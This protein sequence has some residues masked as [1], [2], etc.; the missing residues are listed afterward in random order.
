MANI[1]E[2]KDRH[3][4]PNWRSFENT[5]KLGELNGSKTIQL[6]SSFKPDISDLLEDW[7]ENKNLGV[8]GD[9]LGVAI[10]CNQQN[11]KIV[12]DVSDF[13]IKQ[14]NDATPALIKAANSIRQ[15]KKEEIDF[16]FEIKNIQ[17]FAFRENL[18]ALFQRIKWYKQRLIQNPNNPIAWVE[19]SRLYSINGQ[20]IQAEKAM[21][22][23]LFLAPE[24]R[25][26]LRNMA[27][28][29][30]HIGDIDFAHDNIKKSII[31]QH[32]PWVMATEIALADLRGRGST[33]AKKGIQLI[34]SN[35]FHPFNITEL[36]SS[37]GTLELSNSSIKKS[38]KLFEKSLIHPN[39]NSL[40]QAEWVSQEENRILN[41]DPSKFNVNNSFEA[42]ARDAKE[43][44]NWNKAIELSKNWFLD[45]PFS[46]GGILFGNEIA[47]S[48]LKDHT[49]AVE[50]AKL[51]LVS[52]PN[53]HQLLNNIVYS[54]CL[55]NKIEEAE[56]H[57]NKIRLSQLDDSDINKVCITAT[58]GL[59]HFRKGQSEL[60]RKFY[61]DSMQL[62]K[63]LNNSYL[64]SLA[65]INYS[66]EEVLLNEKD[67]SPIVPK[68]LEIKKKTTNED[69]SALVDEVI[70]LKNKKTNTQHGV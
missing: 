17:T 39:D 49:K 32:D 25:F 70:D 27:R 37:I 24:N 7:K 59:L 52:H 23:A 47:T 65:F 57:F 63:D 45:L 61:L 28:F 29:F 31:T 2:N 34:N 58:K 50:I 20:E 46:K 43:K 19:L 55:D 42:L 35:S 44:K 15:N 54:L 68:L 60:G 1:F 21:R 18:E 33:F 48:K 5:A 4:I 30:V 13:V 6:N 64:S 40:A 41:F 67:L 69:I 22:N 14:A 16:P 66:R 8:A 11:D 51:G 9:I 38:K 10:V 12:K 53:D 3:V 26:V 62:A 36:S 56:K